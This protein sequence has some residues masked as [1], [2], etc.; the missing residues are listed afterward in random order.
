MMCFDPFVM[1]NSAQT[2]LKSIEAS[3]E[4]KV[5]R[6][7]DSH[8]AKRTDDNSTV[9]AKKIPADAFF[10]MSLKNC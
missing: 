3:V 2:F 4:E 5:N 8:S 10:N 1:Q 9:I 6:P 7:Y